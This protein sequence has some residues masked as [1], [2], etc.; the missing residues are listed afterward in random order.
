MK[1][2]IGNTLPENF[3]EY[4]P[5]QY[6]MFSHFEY[7]CSIPH[8]LFAITTRK[9]NG[10]P[11][12]NFH[13]WSCFQGDGAGFFAIL[14]GL[15]QYTHTYAN[16]KRDGEFCVNFL[17][18]KYYDKL[19][20]TIKENDNET[21]EFEMGEF[22]I[23]KASSVNVPR[24][25]ESFL[26]LECKCENIMDLSNAGITAMVIGRVLSMAADEEYAMGVDKKY[27]EDGFMYNIHAPKNLLTGEDD[28]SGIATLKVE[29][30][31]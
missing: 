4:W 26:T 1:I 16:I 14:A 31:Y 6:K 30:T 9:E 17:S 21:D 27:S 29:R 5:G 10:K 7:A 13:S 28:L 8:V 18:Q 20:N 23:E 15:G 25:K 12:V 24:I 19:I 2:E 22:T 3:K 11:N